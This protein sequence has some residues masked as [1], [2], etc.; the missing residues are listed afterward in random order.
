LARSSAV[1]PTRSALLLLLI[2]EK[3]PAVSRRGLLIKHPR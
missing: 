1:L 3:P 2:N